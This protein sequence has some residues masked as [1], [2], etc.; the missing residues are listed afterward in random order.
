MKKTI[1]FVYAKDGKILVLNTYQAQIR[2]RKLLK[3]GWI[4]THT[5][6]A[7]VFIKYLLNECEDVD[8]IEEIRLLKIKG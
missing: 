3:K 5:L 4:H 1:V 2:N 8:L 6:D 7:C